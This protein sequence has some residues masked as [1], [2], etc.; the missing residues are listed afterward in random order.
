MKRTPKPLAKFASCS[1]RPVTPR[2]EA[3]KCLT[4]R[5]ISASESRPGSTDTKT[6]AI[7]VSPARPA[8]GSA[9]FAICPN[10][11]GQISAQCRKPNSTMLQRP[12]S[13]LLLKAPRS[14]SSRK[15]GKLRGDSSHSIACGSMGLGAT[16]AST[17]PSA[18]AK[19]NS[20]AA[21]TGLFIFRHFSAVIKQT[22]CNQRRQCHTR[23]ILKQRCRPT[24]TNQHLPYVE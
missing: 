11:A 8:K 16:K 3:S 18:T 9:N 15:R 5:P 12:V 1:S 20:E 7:S 6:K 19:L 4:N 10:P 22:Q 14:D 24:H 13:A 23:K 17:A 21:I 2:N